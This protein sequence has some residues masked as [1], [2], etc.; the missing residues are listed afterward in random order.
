MQIYV[1]NNKNNIPFYIG[2]SNN[3]SHRLY[4]HIKTYGN[5]ISLEIIDEC[6]DNDWKF[7]E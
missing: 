6:S 3:P 4:N 7:W 5:D 2:K 1:L